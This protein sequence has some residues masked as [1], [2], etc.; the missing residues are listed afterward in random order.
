MLIVGGSTRAAAWSALRAGL[1]PVCADLFADVDLREIADV[2]S[3]RDYPDSLAVDLAGVR[4]DGWF[5]TGALE[6]RPDL[7]DSLLMTAKN[8]GE[9]WGTPPPALRII[10][11]PVRLRETLHRAG[12]PTLDLQVGSAPPCDG[13]WMQK[14]LHSAGGRGVRIWDE[15]SAR[16]STSESVYY[17]RFQRGESLSA[18]FHA[19]DHDLFFLGMCRS[20]TDSFRS[21]APG[22]NMYCGTIGPLVASLSESSFDATTARQSLEQAHALAAC[23]LRGLFGIDLIRDEYG[24]PWVVEVNPRYTASVEILELASRQPLIFPPDR[25]IDHS[26]TSAFSRSSSPDRSPAKRIVAKQV[27]YAPRKLIAP[28]FSSWRG[29]PS[30]WQVPIVADLPVPGSLIDATWPICTVMAEGI[31]EAECQQQLQARVD[32]T[33]DRINLATTS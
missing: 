15:A 32:Q 22:P 16:L 26:K 14:P 18:L 28:D 1:Q 13:R 23:G 30:V 19:S 4:S 2:I 29:T 33:W 9:L 20:L 25:E 24:T 27:L 17:Q 8:R 12:F 5:Y 21:N 10:R 31:N 3:P 11:D 6:N 7:I